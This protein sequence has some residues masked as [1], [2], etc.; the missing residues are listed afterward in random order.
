MKKEEEIDNTSTTNTLG[1]LRKIEN[2]SDLKRLREEDDNY[3]QLLDLTDK[4]N[5]AEKSSSSNNN[6]NNIQQPPSKKPKVRTDDPIKKLNEEREDS[7]R[8]K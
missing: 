8:S 5:V 1:E 3:N 6:T 4:L 2:S 7:Y